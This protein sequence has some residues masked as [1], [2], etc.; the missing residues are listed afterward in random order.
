M[1]TI[2]VIGR[3]EAWRE[4]KNEQREKRRF[5][6][7]SANQANS[8]DVRYVYITTPGFLRGIVVQDYMH[9]SPLDEEHREL[10]QMAMTRVR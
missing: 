9:V 5:D 10:M 3:E 4:W 8:G 1:I 2:A 6:M 7:E